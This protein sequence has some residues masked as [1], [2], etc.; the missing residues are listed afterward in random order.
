MPDKTFKELVLVILR[1]AIK[2]EFEQHGSSRGILQRVSNDIQ[3]LEEPLT[4]EE[5]I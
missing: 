5:L 4:L 1:G 2:E 3:A